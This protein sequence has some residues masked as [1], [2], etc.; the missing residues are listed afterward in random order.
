MSELNNVI[1]EKIKIAM[2]KHNNMKLA[3]LARLLHTSAP[4]L[5]SKF[6]RNNINESDLRKIA[7]ELGYDVEINL[8]NRENGEKI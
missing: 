1:S 2:I 7:N 5:S 3:E 4:N 6:K 8:I